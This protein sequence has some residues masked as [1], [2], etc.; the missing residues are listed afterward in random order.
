LVQ[1]LL[2]LLIQLLLLL[3][4][5]LLLLLQLHAAL[6]CTGVWDRARNGSLFLSA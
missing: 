5:L 1:P 2:H 3:V 6:I 4:L